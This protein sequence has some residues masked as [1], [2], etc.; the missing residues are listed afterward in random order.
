M[1]PAIGIGTKRFL[2]HLRWV[3]ND[4]ENNHCH[5]ELLAKRGV[6]NLLDSY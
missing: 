3:R 4:K 2:T 6:R 1:L 5:F